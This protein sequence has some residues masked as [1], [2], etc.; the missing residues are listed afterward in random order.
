MTSFVF[1]VG[2]L[3]ER[4]LGCGLKASDSSAEQEARIQQRVAAETAQGLTMAQ[5][6]ERAGWMVPGA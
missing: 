3:R 6:A 4:V 5:I 1:I 2:L